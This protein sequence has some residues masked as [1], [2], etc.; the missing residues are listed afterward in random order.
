MQLVQ[1]GRYRRGRPHVAL[2]RAQQQALRVLWLPLRLLGGGPAQPVLG[3]SRVGQGGEPLGA[4]NPGGLRGPQAAL[5]VDASLVRASQ[6]PPRPFMLMGS[7]V[8]NG[9]ALLRGRAA[10]LLVVMPIEWPLEALV[11]VGE[12]QAPLARVL[13]S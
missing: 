11:P 9:L 7:G 3:F 1:R 5:V 8:L 10:L 13:H 4:Q 6:H 2:Q 12:V